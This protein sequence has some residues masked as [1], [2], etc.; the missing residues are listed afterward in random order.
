M[1]KSYRIFKKLETSD[2]LTLRAFQ[3]NEGYKV[4]DYTLLIYAKSKKQLSLE[5]CFQLAKKKQG[6]ISEKLLDIMVR[7]QYFSIHDPEQRIKALEFHGFKPIEDMPK[8]FLREG[9]AYITSNSIIQGK[10][11]IFPRRLYDDVKYKDRRTQYWQSVFE[12]L[13][14]PGIIRVYYSFEY[15]NLKRNA[16]Y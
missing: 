16:K 11:Y 13:N 12:D 1:I 4:S 8:K 5:D 6:V 2:K 9:Y 3:E 7:E 14:L 15:K 10:L